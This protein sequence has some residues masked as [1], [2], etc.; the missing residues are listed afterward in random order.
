MSLSKKDLEAARRQIDA[1]DDELHDLIM[2]RAEAV[3]A[4]GAAKPAG[5]TV[6]RPAREAQVMRR[7]AARHAG[8]F[9]APVLIQIWRELMAAAVM[10]Q[11]PFSVAVVEGD[12]P[13]RAL[14][15]DHF[16]AAAPLA[17]HDSSI[18]ALDAVAAGD[19]TFALLPLPR[20]GDAGPWWPWLTAS[21]AGDGAPRVIGE[22]PFFGAASAQGLIVGVAAPAPS[23]EDETL[24]ALESADRLDAGPVPEACDGAGLGPAAVMDGTAG[25]GKWLTLVQ[26]HDFI[27]P[28]DARVGALTRTAGL[29]IDRVTWLGAYPTP[30]SAP[31]G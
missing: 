3:R 4:V 1:I 10:Q 9:P 24:I 19:A 21:P 5:A 28:D 2:R 30:L 18:G 22:A 25:D 29:D 15:R 27:A 16:G 11:S 20:V 17:A 7:L 14:A 31:K 23:G 26:L 6:Y 13:I 8:G 12:A